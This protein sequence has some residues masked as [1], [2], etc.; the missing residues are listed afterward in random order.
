MKIGIA[1]CG[2]S[3]CQWA[4]IS[5]GIVSEIISEGYNPHINEDIVLT[6]AIRQTPGL[7]KEIGESETLYFYGA[8]CKSQIEQLHLNTI[9]K[10]FNANAK[11]Q[12]SHDLDGAVLSLCR[13]EKGIA[14]ILGTGSNA[15]YFDGNAISQKY[16][17]LGYILGDSGSGSW[18]GRHFI[19]DYF[20]GKVPE[21]L[22][23][24]I[25]I[26]PNLDEVIKKV[27]KG[28]LPNKYLAS[29]AKLLFPIRKT[30]YINQLIT[31]GLNEFL[32]LYVIPMAHDQNTQVHFT[33]SIAWFYREELLAVCKEKKLKTGRI[34]KEPIH[35]LVEYFINL[36][37]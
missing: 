34:I 35:G 28:A 27:Y 26:L 10:E 24:E 4:F 31:N 2:S 7:Q 8:G 33:G 6:N 36:K 3:K 16:P 1:D 19:K 15:A 18:I 12:V 17:S 29:F 22:L 37:R 5:N 25:D 14:C 30:K 11:I 23:T 21:E 13:G 32:D 20:T 9:L